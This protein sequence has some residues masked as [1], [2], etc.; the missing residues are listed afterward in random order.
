MKEINAH[1]PNCGRRIFKNEVKNGTCPFCKSDISQMKHG[2]IITFTDV[3]GK[4][5]HTGIYDTES[6]AK[7]AITH[8]QPG[9]RLFNK[10]P[11]VKK[12]RR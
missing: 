9:D 7:E 3:Y 12:V 6:Q 11:R 8:M 10:N 5:N 4:R 2:Y 1:C